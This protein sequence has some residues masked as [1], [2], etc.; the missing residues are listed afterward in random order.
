MSK[1]QLKKKDS[2]ELAVGDISAD[3]ILK[4]AGKGLE[5]R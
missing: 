5:E 4:S 3:L 2:T 1:Q